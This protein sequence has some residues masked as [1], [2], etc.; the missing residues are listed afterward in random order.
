MEKFSAFRVS[1]NTHLHLHLWLTPA[2]IPRIQGLAYMCVENDN[3][4]KPKEG[5]KDFF[6]QAFSHSGVSLRQ[7]PPTKCTPTPRNYHRSG[8]GIL[9][10][11]GWPPVLPS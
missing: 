1:N 2:T 4:T 5:L 6:A 8:E 9:G 11:C 3:R 7:W 10:D